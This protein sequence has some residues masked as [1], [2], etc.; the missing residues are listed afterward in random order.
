MHFFTRQFLDMLKTSGFS[1][2]ETADGE[3]DDDAL[4]EDLAADSSD[5]ASDMRM[6]AWP[7]FQ[8]SPHPSK[9]PFPDFLL[10]RLPHRRTHAAS[11]PATQDVNDLKHV[12]K[13]MIQY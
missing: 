5:D 8:L 12:L 3:E 4:E 7:R 1:F 13:N 2:S 9:V 11:V 6:Y 10:K